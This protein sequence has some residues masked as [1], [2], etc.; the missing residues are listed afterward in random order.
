ML[1][2]QLAVRVWIHN[3]AVND[4]AK[5]L[6]YK[7]GELTKSDLRPLT[8]RLPITPSTAVS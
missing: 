1:G 5:G 6:V 3:E 4:T 2:M 8:L 7:P